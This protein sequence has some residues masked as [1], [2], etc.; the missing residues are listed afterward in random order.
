MANEPFE[1]T[2]G[3]NKACVPPPLPQG[4]CPLRRADAFIAGTRQLNPGTRLLQSGFDLL[5]NPDCSTLPH[6]LEKSFSS[7][8][9]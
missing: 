1:Q 6:S 8:L 3:V 4:G 5:S 9:P 7:R 2:G